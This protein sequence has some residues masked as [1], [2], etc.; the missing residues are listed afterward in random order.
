MLLHLTTVISPRP[1]LCCTFSMAFGCIDHSATGKPYTACWKKEACRQ[2]P[3]VTG[4]YP[5]C[6]AF[7]LSN[8]ETSLWEWIF[9]LLRFYNIC[10]QKEGSF[11]PSP[12]LYSMPLE[13]LFRVHPGCHKSGIWRN[14]YLLSI[15]LLS[16]YHIK[17]AVLW[18]HLLLE[19]SYQDPERTLHHV[20]ALLLIP[21][22][23]LL[24]TIKAKIKS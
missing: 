8:N 11:L 14:I 20:S 21:S 22:A 2:L 17:T 6:V 15:I 13:D 16:L 12:I 19:L 24:F 3:L 9:F 18:H 7:P 1:V 10:D 5:I 4:N 23:E